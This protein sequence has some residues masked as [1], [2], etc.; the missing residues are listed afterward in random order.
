[1]KP[2]PVYTIKY[3]S[4]ININNNENKIKNDNNNNIIDLN[5]IAKSISN[6]QEG[7]MFNLCHFDFFTD[8]ACIP[9]P[10]PGGCAYFLP[11]F[12]IK[13][14]IYMV[15][16]DTSINYCELFGIKLV[17]QSVKNFIDYCKEN[18]LLLKVN[19]INVFTDSKF[20]CDI[21]NIYGY[22]KYDY[23]YKLLVQIFTLCKELE[24]NNIYININT[25]CS[26]SPKIFL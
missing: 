23:Y 13:S 26:V 4:N 24:N 7:D 14:K 6:H 11:N 1:M 20:I 19:Y 9:N 3:P 16:H 17:L 5:K 22:P 15:D 2:P 25:K 10:G 8:G 12:G 18:S 21:S